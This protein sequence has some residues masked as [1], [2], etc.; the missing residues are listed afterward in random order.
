MVGRKEISMASHQ[1]NN[2]AGSSNCLPRSL[3]FLSLFVKRLEIK[4]IG[5]GMHF[6]KILPAHSVSQN[7]SSHIENQNRCTPPTVLLLYGKAPRSRGT[8]RI[9]AM[10]VM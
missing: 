6:A 7:I 8:R 5:Y 4:P 10:G 2:V 9:S 1:K 3:H